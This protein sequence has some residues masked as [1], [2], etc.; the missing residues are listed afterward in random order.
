[1]PKLNHMFFLLNFQQNY[2]IEENGIMNENTTTTYRV[3]S[4]LH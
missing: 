4:Q 1:M 3:I 2:L